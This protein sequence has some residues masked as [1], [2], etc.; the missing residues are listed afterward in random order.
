VRIVILIVILAVLTSNL[1]YN[2][3][4][5]FTIIRYNPIFCLLCNLKHTNIKI[6]TNDGGGLSIDDCKIN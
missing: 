1:Y 6:E 2:N 3:Y 5:L 4:L